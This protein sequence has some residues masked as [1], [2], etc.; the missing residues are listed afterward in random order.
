MV[1]IRKFY[2]KVEQTTFP[3]LCL[4]L[5]EVVSLTY[6]GGSVQVKTGKTNDNVISRQVKQL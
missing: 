2:L 6:P 5:D 4:L 3:Y 1:Y